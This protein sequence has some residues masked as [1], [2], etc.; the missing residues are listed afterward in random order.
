MNKPKF[1]LDCNV[2]I[3]AFLFKK[4]NPRFALEKA[5]NQGIILLSDSIIEELNNVIQREKFDRYI[6]LNI[7]QQLLDN[8]ITLAYIINP[9]EF[10]N[11]CRDVK[12][13]KYLE[14]LAFSG[15]AEYI[16]TGDNDLLIL[17]PFREINIIKP[18]EFL[19]IML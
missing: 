4:S 18:E 19:S 6:S 15:N 13:N 2:I 17:N 3:S 9:Q 1:V 14:E 11:E 8:L 10:I 7:R 12:D 16:I 5:K